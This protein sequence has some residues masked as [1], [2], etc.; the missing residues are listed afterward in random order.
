MS[1]ESKS[2]ENAP[3]IS[4]G[5]FAWNEQ[6]IIAATLESLFQQT[7]F[8]EFARRGWNCEILCVVN[9]CTDATPKVAES[10]FARQRESHPS[11]SA[12]SARVA[13]VKERGKLNAWNRF[14]HDLSAPDCSSLLMMDADI[15]LHRPDTIWKMIETLEND[16]TPSVVVD[17]PKKDIALKK[18][19]S[20]VDLFSLAMA[21]LTSAASGQLC[22]Q[23]YCI[24][25]AIARNIYLP[26]D[27]GACEDGFIKALVCTDFLSRPICPQ[28]IKQAPGAEHYFQAYTSPSAIFK[29]Q[30][31]Q[32]IGQTVVHILIDQYLSALSSPE[33]LSMAN[34]LRA[35]DDKEPLWLKALIAAHL[36][37]IRFWWRLYPGLLSQRFKNLRNLRLTRRILYLPAALASA[38]LA[39]FTSRAA[40]KF[41]KAGA[42]T[43]WPKAPRQTRERGSSGW[44]PFKPSPNALQTP[45]SKT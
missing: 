16:P 37:R 2:S 38:L 22:G 43:Y 14:V 25:S 3:R 13:E 8:A 39:I 42:T 12:F 4:I 40:W 31:R 23:L 36:Q 28:R 17:Q 44:T 27:L 24:R 7:V 1:S 5:I 32:M 34:F 35:R 33:R 9:G 45:L 11:R 41:L 18:P 20:P 30:K 29:N 26:R 21:N 10:V 6:D 19:R 15:S